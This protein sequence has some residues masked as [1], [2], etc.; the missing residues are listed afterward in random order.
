MKKNLLLILCTLTLGLSS[1]KKEVL[2]A[3][4]SN[5]T[6]LLDIL[7]KEWKTKD[8]GL[9]YYRDISVPENNANFNNRGHIVVAMSF[10]KI[11]V[12][13]GLP[14]V[15]QGLSYTFTS[16]PGYVTLYLRRVDGQASAQ[17]TFDST[18][19]ITLI[20]AELID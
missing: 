15:Y 2:V 11:D 7:A 1:C 17:P 3:E 8:N 16:E 10:E 13:E 9:T 18:A 12:F 6:I 4:P 5:R 14:Q 20:D 19:K